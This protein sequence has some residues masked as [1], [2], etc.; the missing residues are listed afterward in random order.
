MVGEQGFEYCPYF[1]CPRAGKSTSTSAAGMAGRFTSA[2][3]F[4]EFFIIIIIRQVLFRALNAMES[5]SHEDCQLPWFMSPLTPYDPDV[6]GHQERPNILVCINSANLA[7][8]PLEICRPWR[9]SRRGCEASKTS[10]AFRGLIKNGWFWWVNQQTGGCIIYTTSIS[11]G[12]QWR[13]DE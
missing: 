7:G 6:K 8:L 10:E 2:W 9:I 12:Y 13:Y 3:K 4:A 1:H 5:P 11:M